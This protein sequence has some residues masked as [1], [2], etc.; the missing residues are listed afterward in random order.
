MVEQAGFRIESVHGM[1]HVGG[2]AL[3]VV[4]FGTMSRI[5]SVLREKPLLERI[6]EGHRRPRAALTLRALV[7]GP[8][9]P[10]DR[11]PRQFVLTSR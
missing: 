4:P 3:R 11:S 5:Q 9:V 6:A 10:R 7:A 1:G 8:P 2:Q